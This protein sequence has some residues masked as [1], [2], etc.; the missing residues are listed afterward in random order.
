MDWSW[1]WGIHRVVLT[2]Q[3]DWASRRHFGTA[4]EATAFVEAALAVP[5]RRTALLAA[6]G[7]DADDAG[8]AQR[9]LDGSLTVWRVPRAYL[10]PLPIGADDPPEPGPTPPP[11]PPPD[12][13]PDE[14]DDPS[15]CLIIASAQGS[16]FCRTCGT[17]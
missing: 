2:G 14:P 16:P 10:P 17:A 13:T 9:L 5:E 3:A 1:Q 4:A 15:Q 8:L 7:D 6:A 11:A 12:V